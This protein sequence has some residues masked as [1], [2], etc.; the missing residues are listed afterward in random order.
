MTNKQRWII[1]GA[2]G[3]LGGQLC[4]K[5]HACGSQVCAIARSDKSLQHLQD[6]GIS[7][8]TYDE[9][10]SLL[11]SGDVFVHCAGKVGNVGSWMD[12]VKTNRDWTLAL[13]KL[14]SERGVGC[15][16]YV[17]SVA[18]L[19][20][21]SRADSPVIEETTKPL[22][23]ESEYY[24]RSKLL[25]EKALF[26]SA[27]SQSTR[28]V[29]LQPG[30]IYGGRLF[31][32]SQSKLRRSVVVDSNQHI[33]LIHINNFFDA[34]VRVA[35]HHASEGRYL[36]VD[37]EQPTL[38]ELNALKMHYGVLRYAPWHIGK[39]GYWLLW[40]CRTVVSMLRGRSSDNVMARAQAEY[41]FQT[42]RLVY[43]TEKLQTQ[44]G[45]F[46]SATLKDFLKESAVRRIKDGDAS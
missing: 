25:A 3:Y 13:F 11:S 27:E 9:L 38:R 46:P 44:T 31:S 30:L 33:P 23:F 36:V 4:R 32:S 34:I 6:M 41:C 24:G 2:N 45:W 15:F 5:L 18:A 26:Q 21:Q 22:H 40:F 43:S 35:E 19:G 14:A 42:R 29:I 12:F 7:C 10:P 16:I 8:H 28:L 17:S 20:Y 1:T 39:S 37:Q